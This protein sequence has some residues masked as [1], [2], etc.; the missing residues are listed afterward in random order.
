[1]SDTSGDMPT[2]SVIVVSRDRAA[3]LGRTLLGIA[4]LSY[5]NFEVIVVSDPQGIAAAKAS[6]LGPFA[7]LVSFSEPNISAARNAGI[8]LAS[9]EVIAFIDDDAVPEPSWLMHLCAPFL[10]PNTGATGGFV[11]GRNGISFQWRARF[12]DQTGR[13]SEITHEGDDPFVPDIPPGM[14]VRTEGT[15]CAFRRDVLLSLGGFDPAF[16]FYMDE[17]DLNMRLAEMKTRVVIAPIAQVHHGYAPSNQ[18][19]SSRAPKSLFDIGASTAIFLRKHANRAAIEPTLTQLRA[20]QRKRMIAH[21]VAGT[22]EPRDIPRLMKT[23]EEGIS[24]GKTRTIAPLGRISPTSLPFIPVPI[25]FEGSKVLSGRWISR[26]RLRNEAAKLV[27][28]GKRASLFEFSFTRLAHRVSFHPSGYWLQSGG[29][30]GP[31]ERDEPLFRI[32][33]FRRR[34]AK[35]VSRI[36][37]LRQ[38]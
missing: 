35:E 7:K 11:R 22:C 4:Q 2:V 6:I 18:R 15:N 24:A 28:S 29:V 5:P 23:L 8:A 16:H 33:T 26:R 17:T 36:A 30:F 13:H 25:L 10:D 9:G 34:L 3:S 32:T 12:V 1:M 27:A 19:H 21:M 14:A 20:D 37:R 38:F 31:T